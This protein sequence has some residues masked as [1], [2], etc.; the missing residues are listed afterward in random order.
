M[1]YIYSKEKLPKLLFDVNL[2]SDEVKLYG[3]WDIIFGYY[4]NIQKDNSTII[5]RDTP[6]NYPIS[7]NN[8]IREMTRDEKVANDIEITLEVGEFIE[9]KKLIKVPK[10]QENDKYLNW[11]K[12]KHLWILDTEAQKKDYFNVIDDFKNT[13]LE[14]GF[15]YK[16]DGKEHRQKCRDKDIIWIAMSALLLFL[17]K[18]FMGKEIK[19]TWYFEDDF[20]KEMDLMDFIQLM[21]FGSTFIQSVYDTE[22]YFK[23]KVNPKDLSKDEFEKKRKEIHNALAK[24]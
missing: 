11:D 21:F 2:T 14:Y 15:D 18:T 5:E 24:G 9:N 1:Y 17:V 12:E 23:T 10:P 6:F 8:T 4:P 22:N 16:V 19:K 13:S 3:G 20:G 7:D